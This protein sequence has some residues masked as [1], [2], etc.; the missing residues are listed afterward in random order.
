RASRAPR[1]APTARARSL[2]ALLARAAA[3]QRLVQLVAEVQVR[4]LVGALG[5]AQIVVAESEGVE[6]AREPQVLERHPAQLGP[7]PVLA[8][9]SV[10]AA[11]RHA[12]IQ[13]PREVVERPHRGELRAGAGREPEAIVL[14][15]LG[16]EL[17]GERPRPPR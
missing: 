6:A 7:H 3:E 9:A 2:A 12:Q 13:S 17:A 10:Q 8:A 1:S 4:A 16:G 14:G 5:A 15:P 11:R